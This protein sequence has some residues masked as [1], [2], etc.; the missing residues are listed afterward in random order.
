MISDIILKVGNKDIETASDVVSE[1]TKNGIDKQ[2]TI[3]IK[4]N[5][6]FIRLQVL[7]TD[8]TNLQNL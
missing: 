8:I 5:T 1:I 6:R 7:P 2:I 4:R 3:L